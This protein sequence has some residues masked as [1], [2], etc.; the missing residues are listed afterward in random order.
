MAK[1]QKIE[2]SIAYAVDCR[3]QLKVYDLISVGK[4]DMDGLTDGKLVLITEITKRPHNYKGPFEFK[5]IDLE[6]SYRHSNLKG[7]LPAVQSFSTEQVD[8]YFLHREE[9]LITFDDTAKALLKAFNP[10][11]WKRIKKESKTDEE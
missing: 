3:H 5:G 10:E 6:Q 11:Q 7:L 8:C 9:C 2:M 1:K 4:K